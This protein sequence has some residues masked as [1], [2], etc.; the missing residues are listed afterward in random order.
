M[1]ASRQPSVARSACEHV[2]DLGRNRRAPA[3]PDRC[4]SRQAMPR[5]HA[6]AV[7]AAGRR[8]E[9]CRGGRAPRRPSAVETA[10]PG[11]TSTSGSAG[12]SFER[13]NVLADPARAERP[14]GEA[15]RHVGAELQ[16]RSREA[17]SGEIA[18][19]K[20]R[21]ARGAPPPRRPSRRQGRR[22]PG[23][24][25]PRRIAAPARKPALARRTPPP[26]ARRDRARRPA[27]APR[28]GPV[29]AR[30]SRSR[31]T[32]SRPGRRCRRRPRACRADD[33]RPRA[34]P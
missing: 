33:S 25:S 29:T 1:R 19:R 27:H 6:A 34:G 26:R 3:L 32:R 20:A 13:R 10:R 16:R 30:P 9:D 22:P 14:A 18:P 4:G 15:H 7:R 28:N 17:R 2:A 11:Q 5:A 23:C 31:R 12:Q 8:A 24:S 21:S